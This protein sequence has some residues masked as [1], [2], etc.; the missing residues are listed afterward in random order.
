MAN[1]SFINVRKIIIIKLELLSSSPNTLLPCWT[2]STV[3]VLPGRCCVPPPVCHQPIE[4]YRSKT[5]LLLYCLARIACF[6][7]F[8]FC[9]CF[10]RFFFLSSHSEYP[11]VLNSC[12]LCEP[13]ANRQANRHWNDKQWLMSLISHCFE[14]GAVCSCPIKA[15]SDLRFFLTLHARGQ[16][17]APV[18]NVRS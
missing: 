11:Q 8:C 1:N 18:A 3:S 14:A 13:G 2:L 12:E 10:V 9:F 4:I 7:L 16:S 15:T 6:V 17:F 5:L